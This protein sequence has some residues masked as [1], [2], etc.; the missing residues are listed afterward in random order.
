IETAAERLVE[1]LEVDSEQSDRDGAVP[2][3]K[4]ESIVFRNVSFR[5][6]GAESFALKNVSFE[7]GA[8]QTLALVGSSGSGKTT[9][10]KLLMRFYDPTEGTILIN[11]RDLRDYQQKSVRALMGVVLQDV[12]LFNDSIREN[13]AFA[14]P[15]ASV[16]AI[17]AAA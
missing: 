4:L 16:E 15:G 13:I 17:E 7:L 2:L 6:P 10:V 8:G 3:T 9:I 11:G 14:R 5:Y 12:A 1:L